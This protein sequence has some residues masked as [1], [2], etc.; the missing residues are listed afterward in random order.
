MRTIDPVDYQTM[1]VVDRDTIDRW[2]EA[3]GIEPI[4]VCLIELFEQGGARVSQLV[5]VHRNTFHHGRGLPFYSDERYTTEL[6]TQ[7]QL[8]WRS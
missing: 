8:D 4:G 2:L 7:P 3:N 6:T 1:G 5:M